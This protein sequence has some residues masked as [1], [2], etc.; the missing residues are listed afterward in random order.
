MENN[1]VNSTELKAVPN[2]NVNMLS[3]C[4]ISLSLCRTH[5][6]MQRYGHSAGYFLFKKKLFYF[7]GLYSVLVSLILDVHYLAGCRE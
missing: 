7:Q 4:G 1:C 2:G 3:F 5:S 6:S